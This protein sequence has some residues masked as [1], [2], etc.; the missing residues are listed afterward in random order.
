[1]VS[2]LFEQSYCHGF[3]LERDIFSFNERKNDNVIHNLSMTDIFVT[4]HYGAIV[5]LNY[6][7]VKNFVYLTG[8]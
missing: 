6:V 5:Y 7:K 8:F 3:P 2:N 1:M 4:N